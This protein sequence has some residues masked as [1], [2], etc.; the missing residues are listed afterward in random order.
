MGPDMIFTDGGVILKNP[1]T[2]GGTW[3]FCWVDA[4]CTGERTLERSGRVTPA[5]IGLPTVTNNVTELLAAV[6]GLESAPDGWAGT[7]YTDSLVTLRRVEQTE[8]QAKLNGVPEA[9][10]VR[11]AAVK[12]RL[13]AYSVVLLGGH[14][15]R[16]EL[17]EGKRRDGLPC[18]PHN[19]WCDLACGR[20]AERFRAEAAA[21]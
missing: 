20:E 11:L 13:G 5:G 10:C 8:R 14:P 12:S 4:D 16:A 17:L 7:L 1:S 21:V 18:S 9:L 3:A 2:H 6:E 19:V 15:T